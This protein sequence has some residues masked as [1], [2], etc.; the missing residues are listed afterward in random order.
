MKCD[1]AND[2]QRIKTSESYPG[3]RYIL[4]E[5]ITQIIS[6]YNRRM[7]QPDGNLTYIV[8]CMMLSLEIDYLYLMRTAYNDFVHSVPQET[9][10]RLVGQLKA[11]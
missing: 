5:K 6:A 2:P 1:F 3:E 4:R 8:G 7:V 9:Q 10:Q 11:G